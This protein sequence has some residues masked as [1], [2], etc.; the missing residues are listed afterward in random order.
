[1]KAPKAL[2]PL[3]FISSEGF[4]ILVGRNNLQNDKLTCKDSEKTDI[5]FHTK[6]IAG[7]HTIIKCHGLKPSEQT[8]LEA[9]NIAAYHSKAKSSSQVPVDYTYIKYVKK[10]VGAKPGKVIFT[11]NQTLYVSP[12]E[13]LI[14]RLKA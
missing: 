2:P 10:P 1:Q 4:E 3:K 12:D 8:I 11:H 6:D 13:E 14:E 5:W 9:A 7:S